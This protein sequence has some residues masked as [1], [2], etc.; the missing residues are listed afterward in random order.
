M[1]IPVFVSTDSIVD[2]KWQWWHRSLHTATE[3]IRK[4]LYL[5]EMFYGDSDESSADT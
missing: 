4:E 1:Q 5:C 2:T 3:F